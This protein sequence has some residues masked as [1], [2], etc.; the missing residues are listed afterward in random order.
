MFG[1]NESLS[2]PENSVIARTETPLE[3]QTEKSSLGRTEN[4]F[5]KRPSSERKIQ[6]NRQNALRS[7]KARR[8]LSGDYSK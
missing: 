1:P 7:T 5:R 8:S 3:S 4:P 2:Q 6:A